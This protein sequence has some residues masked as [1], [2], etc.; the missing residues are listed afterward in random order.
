MLKS[1]EVPEPIAYWTW[2]NQT[3]LAYVT[4]AAVYHLQAYA[5]GALPEKIFD[6]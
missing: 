3:M 6:R 4:N 2:A 5:E 1:V